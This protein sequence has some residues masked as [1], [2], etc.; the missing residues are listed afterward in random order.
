MRERL[1]NLYDDLESGKR[2]YTRKL[3]RVLWQGL[4]HEGLHAETLLYMLLQRA[5]SGTLPPPYV[6]P[7]WQSLSEIWDKGAQTT[8]I[9]TLGPAEVSIGHDDVEA[10]D[11]NAPA[12]WVTTHE[13]GWD[14]ENPKRAVKVGRFSIETT[15]IT[16]AEYL[17]F[18]EQSGDRSGAF[19]ASWI[20]AEG[21]GQI[22]VRTLYG[23]VSFD[24]AKHWPVAASYDQLV[25]YAHSK[26]GRLPREEELRLYMSAYDGRAD[27]NVGF[28][29]WHYIP[30]VAPSASERGHNGGI[31][32]WTSTMLAAHPGFVP[33]ALYP[34]YSSDFHDESHYVV[35]G[36]SYATIPRIAERTSVRNFYQHNY[37]YAWVGGRVCYEA[38]VA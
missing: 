6:T 4:E 9:V 12:D 31:W 16:N 22:L 38:P 17:A 8:G 19:P 3:G 24:V 26:G 28:K 10:D 37:P 27:V 14:N 20:E 30:P 36:G 21:E 33:S 32:E 1:F 25:A 5:G 15:P 35:L 11:L 7:E 2:E 13:F 18:V 29:N 23:P 34:G